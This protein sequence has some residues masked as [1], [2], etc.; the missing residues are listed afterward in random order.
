MKY[1]F[2]VTYVHIVV[3]FTPIYT[4]GVIYATC[5][6]S[7]SELKLVFYGIRL[8][9][10]MSARVHV[11]IITNIRDDIINLKEKVVL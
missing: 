5:C 11:I 8:N 4:D 10:S 3:H 2:P 1:N 7:K 6:F 9:V